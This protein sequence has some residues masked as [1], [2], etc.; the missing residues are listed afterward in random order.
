M[1]FALLSGITSV[2]A[3]AQDNNPILNFGSDVRSAGMGDIVFPHSGNPLVHSNPS[4]IFMQQEGDLHVGYSFGTTHKTADQGHIQTYH[5]TS[6][7]Y[8]LGG[9]H[10]IFGGARYWRGPQT[11]Y[12]NNIG[13]KMGEI[14]PADAT[15]DLGYAFRVCSHFSVYGTLT[16]LNT[17]SSR[18]GHAFAMSLGAGHNAVIS[19]LKS[20]SY[21]VG[22]SLS[23]VGTDITYPKSKDSRS[24][25]P[26]LLR[27]S[28][29][30]TMGALGDHLITLGATYGYRFLPA[31]ARM[32]T[33]S[34][35][36]EYAMPRVI[37]LRVGGQ[38]ERD[39]SHMTFGL[40]R[41]FGAFGVDLA[42]TMG[43]YPE[44][45]LLRA[46]LTLSI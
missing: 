27:V 32:H 23:N 6:I 30:M 2:S 42:Y 25:L 3:Y 11:V 12:Y 15:V 31:V 26:S 5:A 7:G 28:S 10:A 46:G 1:T 41:K 9:R 4:L 35:G 17:Y 45:N 34:G 39:N 24:Q 43:M 29:A 19:G 20:G 18:T 44:F 8:R 38:Y 37:S 13:T 14:Y 36:G 16:Y 22:I 40:G 21:G 33:V